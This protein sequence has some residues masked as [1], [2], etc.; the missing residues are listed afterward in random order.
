[1][2]AFSQLLPHQDESWM[3][4]LG[5]CCR[6]SLF[7]LMAL[8]G[9]FLGP[10]LMGTAALQAQSLP[11]SQSPDT[12]I[13]MVTQDILDTV[14]NDRSLQS[15]DLT[16]L[17][18][19]V[20]QRVMPVVNFSRMTALTVGIHW[21][22]ASP[23][24]QDKLMAAFRELLLLTYS[25]ALKQVQDTTVQVRPA[26]YAPEDTDV[27][28]RTFVVRTGKEPIQL[29]YRLEKTPAGWKI[30]DFNVL[31]LWLV[32][33]YRSQFGQLASARGIDGLIAALNTKNQSLR[34]LAAKSGS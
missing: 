29:D 26:R 2:L 20:D 12:L 6:K 5:S 8:V 15:G 7:Q 10:T 31:G 18:A 3:R 27:I 9:L 28:V 24:Q 22:R 19:L 25:D 32:D 4:R 23:E 30:Y 11:A 17:N 1:M 13:K 14:R 33:H 16:R 21:R 34:K